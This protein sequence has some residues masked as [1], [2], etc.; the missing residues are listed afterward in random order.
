MT[1]WELLE[2]WFRVIER[3]ARDVRLVPGIDMRT[4]MCID[5]CVDTHVYRG[6]DEEMAACVWVCTRTCA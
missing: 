1:N 3:E 4:D 2:V 5:M 6:A